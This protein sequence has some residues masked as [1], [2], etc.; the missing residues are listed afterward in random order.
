M[1][2]L[3]PVM[4]ALVQ[5]RANEFRDK[6]NAI[7]TELRNR[8]GMAPDAPALPSAFVRWCELKAVSALPAKPD[9][10]A[11]FILE[12][13]D[14]GLDVLS[15]LASGISRAHARFADPTASWAVRAAFATIGGDIPQP[16][17]WGKGYP[18]KLVFADL[19]WQIQRTIEAREADR[20]KIVRHAQNEAADLRKKLK[21]IENANAETTTKAA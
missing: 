7:S 6:D 21:Q 15:D 16:R 20:D 17:S 12:S 19:P 3:S 9:S 1:A 2:N 10:V 13:K 18:G 11:L 4:A 14:L 5:H 8:I